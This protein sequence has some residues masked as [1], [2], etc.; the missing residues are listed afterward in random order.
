MPEYGL[1]QGNRGTGWNKK[2]RWSIWRKMTSSGTY[3][4]NRAAKYRRYA[5]DC[6]AVAQQVSSALLKANMLSM[7]TS[8]LR[9]ADHAEQSSDRGLGVC[10]PP[11]ADDHI[12]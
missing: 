3:F 9:L 6:F 8:W 10:P 5:A 7:A 4:M 11:E 12:Q 1:R 2:P